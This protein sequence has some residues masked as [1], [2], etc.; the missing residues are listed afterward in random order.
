VTAQERIVGR[1]DP[2]SLDD[3]NSQAQLLR[4]VDT[5]YLLGDHD[6][7]MLLERVGASY[8][9]LEIDG[10]RS[11]RY[12]SRYL[13]STE[14]TTF[15]AHVQGRRRRFKCRI[16]HYVD[17]GDWLL[18]V[19]TK[20]ARGETVKYRTPS[21]GH[22]TQRDHADFVRRCL[23][24]AYGSQLRTTLWPV[25][26]VEYVRM[27]LVSRNGLERV[28]L[29]RGLVFHDLGSGAQCHLGAGDWI[30]ETKSLRGRGDADLVL[31]DAHLR[32]NN[33]SKYILG[34]AL[35]RPELRV[36]AYLPII[37]ELEDRA[38][39][40]WTDSRLEMRSGAA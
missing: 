12:H 31:R 15:R 26:D 28:T 29:D 25:L 5:K 37:R 9:A 2:I 6:V 32:P 40:S 4:R 19:K 11:F 35:T 8:R 34:L 13:D 24:D 38:L 30:V 7:E 21:T 27:T 23:D 17:S 36:N 3:A 39:Q 14:L 10:L 33:V 16:R 1:L 22:S 18:E 20:G